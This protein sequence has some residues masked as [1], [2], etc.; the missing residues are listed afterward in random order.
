MRRSTGIGAA[1]IVTTALAVLLCVAGGPAHAEKPVSLPDGLA[2]AATELAAEG[3]APRSRALQMQVYLQPRN[4]AQLDRLLDA[5]QDPDS[6]HYRRFLS[7]SEY[8][9]RFAP[10]Q[11]DVDA[12]RGWLERAGFRVTH[13]SAAEARV[14]FQGTVATAERTF[15]VR[16]AGSRNGRWFGNLDAP[17]VPA[18]LAG[19]IAHLSGLDNLSASR[20]NTKI[21]EPFNNQLSEGHFGPPDVWTYYNSKGLLDAGVDGS[22]QCIA[23]LNGSDVD[24]ESLAMFNTFFGLPPFTQGVNYDVVYP[25]GAPGIAPP[26]SNGVSEAYSEAVLDVEWSHGIAPGAPAA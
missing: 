17:Q 9:A 22:G 12:I 4:R 24:Q 1:A 14:A 11:Q 26:L 7:A 25:D 6:P 8:E 20:M 2:E 13:A 10:A 15:G 16:I 5:L 23:V 18:S 3:R 21:P 19:K